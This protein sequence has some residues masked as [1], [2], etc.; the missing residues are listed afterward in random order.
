MCV[1]ETHEH[2]KSRTRL[3]FWDL[4][5]IL[6]RWLQ[7]IHWASPNMCS[8]QV[9]V[10]GAS[11]RPHFIWAQTGVQS[12]KMIK[13]PHGIIDCHRPKS[14]RCMRWPMICCVKHICT[15]PRRNCFYIPFSYS[16]L[17]LGSY[18][19]VVNFL[20]KPFTFYFELISSK[21]T[22]VSMVFLDLKSLC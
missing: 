3:P 9:I 1:G 11:L 20:S 10:C 7:D 2:P 6:Q 4:L 12:C 21:D 22:I 13:D 18:S 16:V 17:V 15:S 14:Q 19:A 5:A 8:T